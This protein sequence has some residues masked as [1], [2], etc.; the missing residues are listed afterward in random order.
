MGKNNIV[1]KNVIVKGGF[2]EDRYSKEHC[3]GKNAYTLWSITVTFNNRADIKTY[4]I[5]DCIQANITGPEDING[6]EYTNEKRWK[7]LLK[8]Y[9]YKGGY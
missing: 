6:L 5:D 8:E 7:E 2:F 9:N 3:L 4:E 1:T